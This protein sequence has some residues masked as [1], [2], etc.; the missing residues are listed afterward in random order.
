MDVGAANRPKKG[1]IESGDL[2][3]IW[4]DDGRILVAVIDGL[5]HG[6]KA[7]E[8]SRQGHRC[9]E[10]N[11]TSRPGRLLRRCDEA[12]RGTRGAAIAICLIEEGILTHAGVGNVEMVCSSVAPIRALNS[13]GIVGARTRRIN[14]TSHPLHKGDTLV[15]HTDGISSR[16]ALDDYLNLDV[17]TMAETILDHHGKDHDD[18]TCVVLRY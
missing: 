2:H 16:F 15:L 9:I 13:P 17:Q 14:E 3:C 4:R 6:P 12:M 10:R 18:A 1:E 5:G 8:A 11:R 7:A